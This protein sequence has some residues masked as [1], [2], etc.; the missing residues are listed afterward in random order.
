MVLRSVETICFRTPLRSILIVIVHT[1]AFP[2][3]NF[4]RLTELDTH[5]SF[6]IDHKSHEL[7]IPSI[8]LLSFSSA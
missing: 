5:I 7:N 4:S 1:I 8:K 3:I 6:C 2:S